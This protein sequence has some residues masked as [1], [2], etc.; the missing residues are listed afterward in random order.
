METGHEGDERDE[1]PEGANVANIPI[2]ESEEETTM[3]QVVATDQ[4]MGDEQ[5]SHGDDATPEVEMASHNSTGANLS[6]GATNIEEHHVSA[7][8]ETGG[9]GPIRTSSL[10]RALQRSVGVLDHGYSRVPRTQMAVSQETRNE[11]FETS[12]LNWKVVKRLGIVNLPPKNV[13]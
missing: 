9:Y 10:T 13:R 12:W 2:H 7:A 8:A 6:A 1:S 4:S 11:V 3:F 5:D